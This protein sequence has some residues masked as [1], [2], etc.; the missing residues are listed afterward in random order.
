MIN[1]L[2]AEDHRIVRDGLRMLLQSEP[3]FVIVAEAENGRE[4]IARTK[5][6]RPDL[7][8]LDISMPD[9]SGLEA[10]RMIKTESPQTQVLI[11]T[12]HESDEYFFR[13]L[14]AGASGYVLKKAAT[15]D[16]IAAA[17]AV[18]RGEAFLYPS[19][20]KKLIGD[21]VRRV[22]PGT[23]EGGYTSLSDR[24]RE[25]LMLLAQGLSNREIAERLV[26]SQSTLQ[27]HRSHILEKLGL[28]TTADLIKYAVKH[29][30][31]S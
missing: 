6:T 12:M 29:G 16:L 13:A 2:I 1:I 10:T 30:L 17:R 27:T 24:E 15:Q 19:V 21:Y 9:L 18:A 11:L 28:R 31:V 20:A 8:I 7:A 14:Q 26:I 22:Q 5:E 23:E 25:V 3:D 4:A